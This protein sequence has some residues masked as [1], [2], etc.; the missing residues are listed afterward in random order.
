MK[1]YDAVVIGA[2]NAGLTAATAL[3]RGGCRT[4]L[5]ER[6]NIPGG[7]ATS[8]VRG[9][10]EFEVA[11]HQLSGLG[12]ED[13]PFI[14]RQLFEKLGVMDKVAFVQEHALYRLV[15]P[16]EIDIT[17]PASW[18]GI[19]RTLQQLFPAESEA[20]ER[21]LV[22]CE[23]V[24]LESFTTL[25]QARRSNSEA[26][27]KSM[28]PYFVEYGFRPLK[29]VLDEFF[30]D[31]RLKS[32]L[33]TYW[34]YLGV[35]PS[36]LPFSDVA[37]MIYAYAVFK[38]WHIK[39]GS[40]AMSS[41][42]VESFL[43]TGGEVRFNCAVERIIT[44]EGRVRGVRLEGGETVTCA[45]VVS[46]ASPLVTFHELLDLDQ[47]P[48]SVQQD[49]RSRR[50]GT[51]AFVI[52]L[53]LDCTPEELGVRTASSFIYE[54][55]D[56]EAIHQRMGSLEPPLGGMLT[57]YNFE[58]PDAA[59]AGKSQVVLV[60]LQYGE[61][62]KSVP[63]ERYAQTKFEFAEKLIGVIEKVY[64][65]VRQYI[66][67]VEV[68]T[69]LTMMRYLNT[70]GGAIYGFQQST[71][72]SPLLRERLDAVP[73]LYIAGSWTSMGGFQP[74]YLAGEST[75]RAVLKQLKV[76]EVQHA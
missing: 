69:P 13:K 59:P 70:P 17:L 44:A 18:S 42:L 56:E 8:F 10:F 62:W 29:E 71:Q 14:M 7:C 23:K 47:P 61:V 19:R 33:A 5:L 57:C 74:T 65:K 3:Q 31:A 49:F 38:P 73:G 51:S 4:L 55:L 30:D 43:E 48:P 64:P 2:G 28:C 72:D 46:N 54:T 16:G 76:K 15:V 67:E 50:M 35:P 66:E 25:P 26:A 36:M 11:L 6:H 9:D 68:A 58:D 75:A 22:V 27:L 32:V 52:Y 60:C 12:T 20:I 39:G 1:H 24:T 41:A 37:A 34:L 40:Q 45:A 53:G 63:P 21:F